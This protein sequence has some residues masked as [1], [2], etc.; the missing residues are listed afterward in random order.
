[1]MREL[2]PAISADASCMVT[3]IGKTGWEEYHYDMF[4]I[5]LHI[6]AGPE[7]HTQESATSISIPLVPTHSTPY[8]TIFHG[9]F[10]NKGLGLYSGHLYVYTKNN[11][12]GGKRRGG[13]NG[14]AVE[15]D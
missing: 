12:S 11:M 7:C 1:M 13:T 15:H 9:K 14:Y 3:P 10:P 8:L 6:L 2:I 4:H 5:T